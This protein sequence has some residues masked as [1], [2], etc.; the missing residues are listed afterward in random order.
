MIASLALNEFGSPGV[1]KVNAALLVFDERSFI[2]PL[3]FN[4][5]DPVAT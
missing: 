5:N 2:V 4:P 3:T 1:A